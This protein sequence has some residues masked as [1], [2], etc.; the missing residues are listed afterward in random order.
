MP[1]F[2]V[3]LL[4]IPSRSRLGTRLTAPR[5]Y[6][7]WFF[8]YVLLV[9]PCIYRSLVPLIRAIMFLSLLSVRTRPSLKLTHSPRLSSS[10]CAV[11]LTAIDVPTCCNPSSIYSCRP[12]SLPPLLPLLLQLLYVPTLLR[13]PARYILSLIHI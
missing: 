10:C 1:A 8:N 7:S 4:A 2:V 3:R 9:N 5:I 6:A 13:M 12:P 11:L